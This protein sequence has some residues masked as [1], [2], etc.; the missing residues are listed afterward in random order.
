MFYRLSPLTTPPVEKCPAM[1]LTLQEVLI[2]GNNNDQVK[3]SELT[4]DMFRILQTLE[5]EPQEDASYQ[6]YS[7]PSRAPSMVDIIHFCE[8]MICKYIE[9][10]DTYNRNIMIA[11]SNEK[12]HTNICCIN[13]RS[14][15]SW[16]FSHLDSRSCLWTA[17][18]YFIFPRMV[19]FLRQAQQK[20]VKIYSQD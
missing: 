10:L 19:Y 20:T 11:L 4:L 12:I 8:V 2:I 1:D 9:C 13:L 15:N 3:F 17:L 14:V 16:Y 6:A 18:Y 7:L 5:R